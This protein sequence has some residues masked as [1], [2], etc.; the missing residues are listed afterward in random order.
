MTK[1]AY[2]GMNVPLLGFAGFSS[3][4]FA[5]YQQWQ[6]LDA[7][8]RKGEKGTQIIFYKPHA[9]TDKD[10]GEDKMIPVLKTFTVFNA[11][12]VDNA[13]PLSVIPLTPIERNALCEDILAMT[14][15]RVSYR[16]DRAYY[17]PSRDMIQMP[18]P[19]QFAS[20]EA[21][22]S[23]MWHEA[24]HWTGHET[25]LNRSLKGRF[26]DESY[27]AEELIAE[28]SA[29]LL[30]ATTGVSAQP[31]KD[32]A[33][34][35]NSWVRVLK[36]DKRAIFHAFAQSQKAADFIYPEPK[37]EI[38]PQPSRPVAPEVGQGAAPDE[39]RPS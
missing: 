30:C 32:H 28:C 13:P 36:S 38:E 15:A 19:E 10:T 9:V 22:W 2:R 20:S 37:P 11:D 4:F 39:A 26:G 34:Y 24:A 18:K 27:A 5:T 17:S 31:R 25:R 8:V 14:G 6:H 12:Q 35:L 7:Q 23:V 29:A 1:R 16:G 33:T 21:Y 3:P